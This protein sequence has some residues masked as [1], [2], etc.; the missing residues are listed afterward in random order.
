MGQLRE[1]MKRDLELAEYAQKTQRVYLYSICDLVAF[2]GQPPTELSPDQ[3]RTWVEALMRGVSPQ[4]VRQHIAALRFLYMKT[5]YKPEMVSFLSCPSERKRLP[6]VMA[7]EEIEKLLAAFRVV[8]YRVLFATLYGTGLRIEEGCCLETTD[9]DAA[10]QVIHVREGKGNKDRIVKLSPRLL[11]ILR[12]YWAA[13]RP[14]APWL[15]ASK[16][17]TRALHPESARKAM[18]AAARD[19]GLEKRVTPHVL[20]HSFATHLLEGGTDLRVIQMLLG[21]A[22]ISTTA[23]YLRVSTGLIARTPSPI[24]GIELAE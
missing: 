14:P 23:R 24:D 15:F 10:R 7:Q 8:K 12:S 5:L 19:A 17:R 21:H 1:R 22:H 13:E 9:I 2:C 18:K 16:T 4:R 3:I 6:T 11:K 20:R